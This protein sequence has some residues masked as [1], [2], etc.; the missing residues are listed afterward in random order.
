LSSLPCPIDSAESKPAGA[1]SDPDVLLQSLGVPNHAHSGRTLRDHLKGTFVLLRSWGC[2][3]VTCVAGLLHSI[4]G[5]NA[6][7]HSCLDTSERHRLRQLV[8]C[9]TEKLVYLF[10]A[11]E[12]PK[13]FLQAIVDS[14]ITDRFD[15]SKHEVSIDVLQKL[16]AIECANLIEQSDQSGFITLLTDLPE[17]ALEAILGCDVATGIRSFL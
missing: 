14:Q 10:C 8:G 1:G 12:R 15:G 16:I 9:D 4:Y 6:F 5:T 7:R 17:D 3:E 2:D 13:A 11:S